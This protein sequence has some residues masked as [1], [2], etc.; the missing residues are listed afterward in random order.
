MK[1]FIE[2]FG[3]DPGTLF[4]E[5]LDD[6]IAENNSDRVIETFVG[7]LDLSALGFAGINPHLKAREAIGVERLTAVADRGHYKSDE[8]LACEQAGITAVLPRRQTSIRH[9]KMLFGQDRFHYQPD[10]NAHRC[11]AGESLTWRFRSVDDGHRLARYCGRH[12]HEGYQRATAA[13]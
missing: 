1:H 4:P 8:I 9:L 13:A 2:G 6:F 5:G 11:P 12:A 3:R 10:S 7:A